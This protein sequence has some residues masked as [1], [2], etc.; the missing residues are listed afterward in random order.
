MVMGTLGI[1]T[2]MA[3][4]GRKRQTSFE[5]AVVCAGVSDRGDGGVGDL[6]DWVAREWDRQRADR[7][8]LGDLEAASERRLCVCS[9]AAQVDLQAREGAW[10]FGCWT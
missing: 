6:C 3:K 9:A 8:L 10:V 5:A 7:N 1:Y 4:G 2:E